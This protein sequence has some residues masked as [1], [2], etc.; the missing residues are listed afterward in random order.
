M[1][2]EPHEPNPPHPVEFLGGFARNGLSRR[3]DLTELGLGSPQSSAR[4]ETVSNLHEFRGGRR[5]VE[6]DNRQQ[7]GNLGRNPST[8]KDGSQKKT[9]GKRCRQDARQ[10]Q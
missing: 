3:S 4:L 1:L 7:C 10:G 2:I 9:Y 5:V 6:A 8:K